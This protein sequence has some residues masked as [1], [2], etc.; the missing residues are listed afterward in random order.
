MVNFSFSFICLNQRKNYIIF[1]FLKI[2]NKTHSK[3]SLIKVIRRM[4]NLSVGKRDIMW[5]CV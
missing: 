4:G 1:S 2:K 5:L 3:Y